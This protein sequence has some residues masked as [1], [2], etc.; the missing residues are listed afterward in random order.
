MR[1]PDNKGKQKEPEH[2]I[3]AAKADD[4]LITDVKD[5]LA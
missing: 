5:K 1:Q 4:I 3:D 2:L